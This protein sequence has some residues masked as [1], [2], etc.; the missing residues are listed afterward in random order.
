MKTKKFISLL[1]ILLIGSCSFFTYGQEE[2]PKSQILMVWKEVV[3]PSKV[4]EYEK[5]FK[6]AM[7]SFKEHNY[8]YP[9]FLYVTE[10]NHY[11]LVVPISSLDDIDDVFAA[12][13][14]LMGKMGKEEF[15]KMHEMFTGT[16]EYGQPMIM[17]TRP[18]LSYTPEDMIENTDE[19]TFMYWG[20]CSGIPGMEKEIETAFKKFVELYS[21]NNIQNGWQTFMGSI[22]TEMPYYIYSESG[23]SQAKFWSL[24]EEINKNNPE[25][26]K[27]SME[28][29]NKFMSALRKFETKT[30]WY[31]P[32]LSY[33]PQE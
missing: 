32:D 18:D 6:N 27:Q 24:M 5:A 30:G 8:R 21:S 23:K 25:L 13:N 2:K 3:K 31:R 15:T 7:D 29:W 33:F 20:F 16:Y 14:E 9:I 28:I 10:D 11:Y 26:S 4:G 1:I 19:N 17:Y 22:G 12:S